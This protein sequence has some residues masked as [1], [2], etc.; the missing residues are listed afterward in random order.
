[1]QN[2]KSKLWLQQQPEAAMQ[3]LASATTA[4]QPLFLQVTACEQSSTPSSTPNVNASGIAVGDVSAGASAPSD[5]AEDAAA[6]D[7]ISMAR[8]QQPGGGNSGQKRQNMVEDAGQL[9]WTVATASIRS[10]L[11]M[12]QQRQLLGGD[13]LPQQ[14]LTAFQDACYAGTRVTE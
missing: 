7:S 10:V 6:R 12:L 1:M 8:A 3:A 4:L 14:A 11:H 13:V 5:S 9:A 2:G